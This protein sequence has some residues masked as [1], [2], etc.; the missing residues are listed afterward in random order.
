MGIKELE[1]RWQRK[2]SEESQQEVAAHRDRSERAD[3]KN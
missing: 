2:I 1:R 3:I